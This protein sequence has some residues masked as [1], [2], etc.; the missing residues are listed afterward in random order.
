MSQFFEK[1]ND[2]RY[3]PE[4]STG[5]YESYFMRANSPDNKQAFWMRYTVFN[6]KGRPLEAL[7]ELWVIFFEKGKAPVGLKKELPIAECHFAR[8]RFAVRVGEAMLED[9]SMMGGVSHNQ[10]SIEWELTFGG[11]RKPMLMFPEQ[12][13]NRGF[14]KAKSIVSQPMAK[15]DGTL[16][17]NGTKIVVDSWVGSQNHNWGVKHTDA[18]A[19]GQVA[20][21]DDQPDW[22][23]E[24]ATARVK[25][26]P[27]WTPAFTPISLDVGDQQFYF[28]DIR[29]ALKAS[30]RYKFFDWSFCSETRDGRLEGRIWADK[31]SVVGLNY[32]NPPGGSKTCLNTKMA[33]CELTLTMFRGADVGRKLTAQT[34]SR[35]AFEILTDSNEHGVTISA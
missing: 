34:E 33:S 4:Q 21:F 14:P 23:L 6:P 3:D 18:Y 35:A 24:L 29:Q 8:D 10:Q 9:G 16:L 32:Y 27:F 2:S 26:G 1:V 12:W 28:H 25:I 13:Y 30:G 15:F 5:L 31:Q 11:G 22:F 20:G 17:V 7:G 19:W